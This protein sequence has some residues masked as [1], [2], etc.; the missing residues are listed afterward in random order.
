[1]L[2]RCIQV[3][4]FQCLYGR[5]F[6]LMLDDE[7]VEWNVVVD[8]CGMPDIPQIIVY[9]VFQPESKTESQSLGCPF[10]GWNSVSF[11]FHWELQEFCRACTVWKFQP[12][13]DGIDR[14]LIQ[15][16]FDPSA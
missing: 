14:K 3:I 13:V 9:V 6:G 1:M 10:H 12:F 11:L 7:S 8:R 4:G 2:N 5:R 16:L 15:V